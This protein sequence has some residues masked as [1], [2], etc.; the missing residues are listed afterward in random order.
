[1]RW[2][3][4]NSFNMGVGLLLILLLG[5]C[6]NL[7]PDYKQPEVAV[8]PNWLDIEDELVTSQSPADPNWWRTAFQNPDINQFIETALQQN[9]TLR[10][11]GLADWSKVHGHSGAPCSCPDH[12]SGFFL[13]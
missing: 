12:R 3:A 7:G 4:M 11:A 8:E 2:I 5:G 1:M 13:F 9:L 10:S 6:I